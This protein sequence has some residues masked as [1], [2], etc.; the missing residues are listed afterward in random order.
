VSAPIGLDIIDQ[1]TGGGRLGTFDTICPLCSAFRQSPAN[2]RAKVFRIYRIEAAFAGFHCVHCGEKGHAR[3]RNSPPPDPVKLAKARAESAERNL[4]HKFER[5]DRARWLWSVRKPI[6]DSPA[7]TYLRQAR[8]Y[9]GPLPTTLGFLPPRG[10]HSPAMVAA[11]GIPHEVEPGIISIADTAVRGVHLTRLAPDGSG[12]AGSGKDKIMVGSSAGMPI[13]LAPPNDLLG[14]VITEGIEDALSAHEA[15]GLGAWAAGCASRLPAL[16]DAVQACIDC[17]TVLADDDDDGR[18]FAAN[19]V[20][21]I[22]ARGIEA[23]AIIP[24]IRLR[25]AA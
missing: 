13:V 22:T 1:L 23:T 20:N 24:G 15:T 4:I 18:R 10:E 9:G 7:A 21:R 2:R 8:G 25:G 12:K 14:L 17:I 16:A 11:F 3:D 19:L 5:L 6:V